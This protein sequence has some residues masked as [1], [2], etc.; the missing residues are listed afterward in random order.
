MDDS[1]GCLERRG[2]FTK[3]VRWLASLR[4]FALWKSCVQ[5][6]CSWL[7][8]ILPGI[9][10][11]VDCRKVN[12][13]RTCLG[14]W[15]TIGWMD[16]LDNLMFCIYMFS[17]FLVLFLSVHTCTGVFDRETFTQTVSHCM[18]I[19]QINLIYIS[20]EKTINVRWIYMGVKRQTD[21]FKNKHRFLHKKKKYFC[22]CLR[23]VNM[24]WRVENV[25]K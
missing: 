13:S 3:Q 21:T 22:P 20:I 17:I 2:Y 7:W 4:L 18:Y 10:R 8:N 11:L 1:I 24:R 14:P 15:K 6:G 16:Q 9:G 23:H 25:W 19:K 5:F 12:K